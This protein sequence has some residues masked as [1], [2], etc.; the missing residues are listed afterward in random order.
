MAKDK[1]DVMFNQLLLIGSHFADI[2]KAKASGADSI[3]F[4]DDGEVAAV[5]E[6]PATTFVKGKMVP[7]SEYD[8]SDESN[9]GTS[10]YELET[11]HVTGHSKGV[12]RFGES[13]PTKT[14]KTDKN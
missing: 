4:Y 11:L 2:L 10:V 14:E 8:F 1:I 6:M 12:N 7:V 9:Y 3:E 13:N 5:Y